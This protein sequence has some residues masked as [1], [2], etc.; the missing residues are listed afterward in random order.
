MLLFSRGASLFCL[1]VH[2]VCLNEIFGSCFNFSL[3]NL[4]RSKMFVLFFF[5]SDKMFKYA[6]TMKHFA[7]I[8]NTARL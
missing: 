8:F 2:D 7:D 4:C 5:K 6:Q 3:V 1:P